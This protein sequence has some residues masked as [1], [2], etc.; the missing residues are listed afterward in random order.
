MASS[1]EALEELLFSAV[2]EGDCPKVLNH[3]AI[4]PG[5]TAYTVSLNG[6]SGIVPIWD[7]AN[8]TLE[9]PKKTGFVDCVMDGTL[10]DFTTVYG[11][12]VILGP[13]DGKE[14]LFTFHPGLPIA[15]SALKAEEHE[16]IVVTGVEAKELGF[17]FAKI[18]IS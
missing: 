15:P 2:T 14:V 5:C 9:D 13:E 7:D 18:K 4:M 1:I 16:G 12:T 10:E 8:Y 6:K 3:P 17:E 11:T